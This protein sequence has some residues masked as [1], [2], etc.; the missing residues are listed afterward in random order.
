MQQRDLT[1]D[2]YA[3]VGEQ[4]TEGRHIGL[5]YDLLIEALRGVARGKPNWA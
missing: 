4:I 1:S 5:F 2:V 3:D